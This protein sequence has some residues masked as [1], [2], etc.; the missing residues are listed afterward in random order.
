M[1]NDTVISSH[2]L[3]Q[4]RSRTLIT[5]LIITLI[6]S[7]GGLIFLETKIPS[8]GLN[9]F[10]LLAILLILVCIGVLCINLYLIWKNEKI[11]L[12]NNGIEYTTRNSKQFWQWHE[13]D[14][15]YSY[16]QGTSTVGQMGLHMGNRT[17][18]KLNDRFQ[19]A[20]TL[21]DYVLHYLA[22][23]A[24]YQTSFDAGD[25]ISVGDI[26]VNRK[27]V[28]IKNNLISWGDIRAIR[29]EQFRSMQLDRHTGKSVSVNTTKIPNAPL[30]I[31]FIANHLSQLA[32]NME[33]DSLSVKP[34]LELEAQLSLSTI[35]LKIVLFA[36]VTS[37][38]AIPALT[39]GT[40]SY[41][42]PFAVV[43]IVSLIGVTKLIYRLW[44]NDK[45]I[46]SDEGLDHIWRNGSR[47]W[48]WNEFT[49]AD[50]VI[51]K[52]LNVYPISGG[53]TLWIGDEKVLTIGNH[54]QRFGDIGVAILNQVGAE[55]YLKYKSKFD[56]D[57]MLEFGTI[58]MNSS[59]IIFDKD[60]F[61]WDDVSSAGEINVGNELYYALFDSNQNTLAKVYMFSVVNLNTAIRL[62]NEK[63][64]PFK[65]DDMNKT[66]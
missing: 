56:N 15:I 9:T 37:A 20:L 28:Q 3:N 22:M 6:A 35:T 59:K 61:D 65:A 36:L 4:E 46:A 23:N 7:I 49:R 2:A 10:T 33:P 50:L 43:L 30:I 63:L 31:R 8:R 1:Q 27:G 12:Y 16:G 5:V 40:T 51:K 38:F 57:E 55:L 19:S 58:K 60:E 64:S 14:S 41:V 11:T 24:N 66:Q 18:I 47:H 26:H 52:I 32:T 45:L 17:I 53:Y 48:K 25:T 54:F 34:I 21:F 39:L 13:I 44:R 62:I 29:Q 42:I